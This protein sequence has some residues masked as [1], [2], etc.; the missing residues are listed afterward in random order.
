MRVSTRSEFDVVNGLLDR[1]LALDPDY[2]YAKALKVRAHVM[3]TGARAMTHDEGRAALQ[4]AYDLLDGRQS[5][6]LVLA[7]AGHMVAYL[8]N[9]HE[10]GYRSILTAKQ[11][12]RNSVI[13]CVSAAWVAAYMGRYD[14]AIAHAQWAYRLNPLDPNL[15][16]CRAAHG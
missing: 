12:N 7:F 16:H 13:V 6:P 1:A 3:A 15:G 4:M 14:D 10:L 8:G 5:D 11:M 2:A 9:D